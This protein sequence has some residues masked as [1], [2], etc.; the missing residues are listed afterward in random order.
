MKPNDFIDEKTEFCN[1]LHDFQVFIGVLA[2][3][4]EKF[5]LIVIA[6]LDVIYRLLQNFLSTCLLNTLCSLLIH[7]SY[8]S[9]R[10]VLSD[11]QQSYELC[12][13]VQECH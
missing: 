4:T 12:R 11:S 1:I 13:E 9:V 2:N 3:F 10:I 8:D 6:C 7:V 5:L